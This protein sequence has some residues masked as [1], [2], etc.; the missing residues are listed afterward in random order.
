M[1][2]NTR[3]CRVLHFGHSDPLQCYRPGTEQ[4]ECCR[5]EKDLGALVNSQLN[6]RAPK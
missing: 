1:S 5:K 3:K 4:L 2:F 6:S